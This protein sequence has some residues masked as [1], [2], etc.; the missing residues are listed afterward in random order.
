[1]FPRK[2]TEKELYI[3]LV[4]FTLPPVWWFLGLPG[5]HLFGSILFTLA[6]FYYVED[7]KFRKIATSYPLLIWGFLTVY[8]LINA[9]YNKVPEVNALDILHGFKIYACIVLVAYWGSLDFKEATRILLISFLAR[10]AVGLLLIFIFVGFNTH[11]RMTGMGGSAT[12]TGQAAAITGI[13]IAYYNIF[14]KCSV[15]KN[16]LLFA[17]PFIV[18][19]FT[20]SRNS[21]AMLLMSVFTTAI[22]YVNR[23]KRMSVIKSITIS[24]LLVTVLYF[25]YSIFLGT[26]FGHRAINV[27]EKTETD[28]FYRIYSTGTI[29]DTIVGDRLIYYVYGWDLFLTKPIT[30]IG[31]WNYMYLTHGVY[32]LHSEYMV[33]LC[34]GGMI[35]ITLW[36]L[37]VLSVI[38]IILKYSKDIKIKVSALSSVFVLLFC[39][40]YAREF[41]SE[42]FYPVYGLALAPYFDSKRWILEWLRIKLSNIK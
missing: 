7:I 28:K 33:H 25:S 18:I 3:S 29:F 16:C 9:F 23:E 31:M 20:Q 15:W 39:G 2:I 42:W 24:I 19:I 6:F 34:E 8:H 13:F 4:L 14:K 12:Q 41:Y 35:G 5:K 10:C 26:D 36:S 11:A 38:G 40:I 17:L 1:M 32:P 21:L 22:M 27:M 37:F 30:G